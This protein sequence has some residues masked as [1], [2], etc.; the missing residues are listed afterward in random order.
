MKKLL[1]A[2]ILLFVSLFSASAQE[3]EANLVDAVKLY[4]NGQY[5]QARQLLGTLSAAAPEDDAVWYYLALTEI[6]LQQPDKAEE[7]LKKAVAL[8]GGNFW[9]RRTLG[10]VYLLRGST[11][12]ASAIYEQLVKDFP[13]K[14]DTVLELLEIYL[15]QGEYNKALAALQEIEKLHGTSEELVRTQ[16]DVL[17]AMG[18]Q[19]EGVE[20]LERFNREYSSSPILSITGD[21]YLSEFADSLAQAR[22]EEALSL[23][24]TYAPA[25]LGLAEVYRHQRRYPDY[26]RTLEPFV[27]SQDIPAQTKGMYIGNL[28]R[29]IDPKILQLHREGFDHLVDLAGETHPADTS[30]LSAAATY[31]YSTG[32]QEEAGR[33]LRAS[34]E[35]HPESLGQTVTYIQYLALLGNWEELRD[36]SLDAFNRFREIAFLNYANA[37]NFQLEDY[38]AVIGNCQ[39]IL[40]NYPEEKD[41]CRDALG[42]MG[43]AKHE[44]G[45]DKGAFKAYDKALKLDP[46]D[47]HVL[48]NYAYYLSLTGK[49]LKKAYTMSKKTVEAEPD[50]ATFLDT[51]G[52]ILH[53]MGKDLEAKSIFKHAML[54]GGK[55]SVEVLEH[56]V[57]V[58]EALGDHDTAAVYRN[59]AKKL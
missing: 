28:T 41:L 30:V 27:T 48:N 17:S 42:I 3:V 12:D 45:D 39:W 19:E 22:Y 2:G 16:Y 25:L 34:A 13:G 1:L 58:L 29:G 7:A 15:H 6:A 38:D 56:Y 53:L 21:Y 31:Y 9:Y 11:E 18:R 36:R 10:R 23:D 14:S 55:D 33:W 54:Y 50:N 40:T 24:G 57:A 59:M 47:T 49:K 51:F 46:N 32:R 35:A 26:F 43:D 4:S 52:W 5:K 37:A 44:K 20:V 8:D